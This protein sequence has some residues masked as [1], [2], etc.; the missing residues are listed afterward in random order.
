M[1]EYGPV[2]PS[3]APYFRGK[4]PCEACGTPSTRLTRVKRLGHDLRLCPGCA[5]ADYGTCTGCRRHRLLVE[6]GDGRGLCRK[7]REEGEIPCPS[8]GY[9]MMAGRGN[10]CLDCYYTGLTEKRTRVDCAAFSVPSM[11]RH[12]ETF[13]RWLKETRGARKAA[14]TIHRYLKFFLE[15]ERQWQEIPD[16]GTMLAHFGAKELRG[17]LLPVRW[18]EEAG[19]IHTD[20]RAR[21]R[22][23]DRRRIKTLIE[24]FP[25]GSQA[26]TIIE[27]YRDALDRRRTEGR[28]TD[29]SIR[30]ALAPAAGLL[31]AT[32]EI[33]ETVPNQRALATYLGKAPGQRAALIGFIKH[34]REAHGILLQP[35]K[36]KR[37]TVRRKQRGELKKEL[38]D[39]MRVEEEDTET[40][41]R[42]LSAALAYFHDL[43]ARIAK[44][45]TAASV[46][47]EHGG[48]NVKIREQLYWI[49]MRKQGTGGKS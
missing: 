46:T 45:V 43:P 26:R 11:A 5:R 15:I 31:S 44:G 37:K 20:P 9:P 3:C 39:L 2:C 22:D 6:D 27:T 21:E 28:T 41:N 49:P 19:I 14:H 40:R 33:R 7:C 13:G 8:C 24:R 38:L 47:W 35:P 16:Y 1:T 10:E 17:V 4:E 36:R 48:M 25:E 42:W 12:F 34:M 29:R 23:S 18:M 32:R 30:L